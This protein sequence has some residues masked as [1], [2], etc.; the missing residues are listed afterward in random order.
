MPKNMGE[1][2]R[3]RRME[4]NM[5]QREL[6][7]RMGYTDHTT[8]TRIEAGKSDPPQSR[9]A[10]FAKVLG[11]TPGHLMGWDEEPEELGAIAARVLLDPG[12]LAMVQ[13]YL[14]LDDA[15]RQTVRTLVASLAAKNKKD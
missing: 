7:A 5:T 4:L 10:Q 11:V 8:I 13:D 14:A 6:A 12:A 2:I 3:A 15:D 9:V 1:R